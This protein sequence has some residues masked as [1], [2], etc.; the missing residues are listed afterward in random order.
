MAHLPLGVT[1]VVRDTTTERPGRQRGKRRAQWT[2]QR[3]PRRLFP[4]VPPWALAL[5][6]RAIP[7]RYWRYFYPDWHR[8]AV[9]D[10]W[11]QLGRL[12]FDF[13]V[14]QGLEPRHYLLDVG[15]G[16]L[17]GGVHFIAYLDEGH[18][19]GVD[20]HAGLL[21]QGR[22]IELARSGLTAKQPTL[23]KT[24]SFDFGLLGRHFDYAIAQSLFS[25]LSINEILRC[26]ANIEVALEP[27]GKFFATFF[28]TARGK[29]DFDNIV[30]VP[31]CVSHLD[32]DPFH[33]HRD[34][35]RWMCEGLELD[36]EY[37]GNWDHPGNQKMMVF[38]RGV[39]ATPASM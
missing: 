33:Y 9:G 21:Q 28:E 10:K 2:S 25:H 17:R 22:E 24:G 6:K 8:F 12:Q 31:G 32:H 36:P 11:D 18:Y 38:T 7:M 23:V 26:L 34:T 30:Q 15:C 39:S 27:G 29:H 16:S 37:L 20:R 14:E 13:L 35:F 5:I 19:Y 4:L 1:R 3:I